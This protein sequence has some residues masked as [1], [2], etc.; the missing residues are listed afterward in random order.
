MD[1][2]VTST[3]DMRI[4]IDD[5]L[6]YARAASAPLNVEA[7][8]LVEIAAHARESLDAA[9][10]DVAATVQIGE[11]PVV[12]GDPVKLLRVLQNLLSNAAKFARPATP[13]TIVVDAERK[14]DHWQIRVTDDGIGI[15]DAERERVFEAFERLHSREAIPGSGPRARDVPGHRR[16]PWRAHLDGVGPSG[17]QPIGVHAAHRSALRAT[18]ALR[19]A[20]R[21][22]YRSRRSTHRRTSSLLHQRGW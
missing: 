15:P 16:A 4:V 18:S 14:G 5:L 17:W 10:A 21:G 11:L 8:D 12:T 19:R 9:L 2:I 7:V 1:N 3:N 6:A 13:P 20:A 22:A